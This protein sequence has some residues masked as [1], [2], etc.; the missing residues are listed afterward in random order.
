MAL[1][2]FALTAL[3]LLRG[4]VGRVVDRFR[5]EVED[6]TGGVV[7][8]VRGQLRAAKPRLDATGKETGASAGRSF[9]GGILEAVKSAPGRLVEAVKSLFP[10]EIVIPVAITLAGIAGGGAIGTAA[11][12][13]AGGGFLG[14]GGFLAAQNE[15]VK[16]AFVAFGKHVADSAKGLAEPFVAPMIKAAGMLLAA[17]D[18]VAPSLREIFTALAPLIEPLTAGFIGLVEQALPGLK[19]AAIAAIPLVLKLAEHLPRIGKSLGDF[20][21]ILARNAPAFTKFLDTLLTTVLV[22]SA[23][24][25]NLIADAATA[26][27]N[28]AVEFGRG[29][30]DAVGNLGSLLFSAGRDVVSGFVNGIRSSWNTVTDSLRGLIERVPEGIRNALGIRSP[31]MVMAAIG[32]QIPAGLELGIRQGLPGVRSAVAGMGLTP[33]F[34]GAGGTMSGQAPKPTVNVSVN[35]REGALGFLANFID[36][37]VDDRDEATVIAVNNGTR[38]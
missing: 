3:T 31:S 25:F 15:A 13:A 6:Q 5:R 20:F 29:V 33:A 18:R 32:R 30:R 7:D 27:W 14:L 35:V 10:S 16:A 28:R 4:T 24:A 21:V 26:A 34:A 8:G 37:R 17:W 19:E 22:Q 2:G 11:L 36:V 9:L 38:L 12:L 23:K 1:A